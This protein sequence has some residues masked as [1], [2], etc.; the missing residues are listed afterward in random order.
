MNRS[1]E[2]KE[3]L[4]IREKG[5]KCHLFYIY[6]SKPSARRSLTVS[7]THTQT[8]EQREREERREKYLSLMVCCNIIG[9]RETFLRF[10]GK[11]T[12]DPQRDLC[13]VMAQV[14]RHLSTV[15]FFF[16]AR[17]FSFRRARGL[18]WHEY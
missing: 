2:R 15:Y 12:G 10:D 3:A 7:H 17:Y 1:A 9:D 16:G 5:E 18:S 6:S 14:S 11:H 4:K 13:C 8:R